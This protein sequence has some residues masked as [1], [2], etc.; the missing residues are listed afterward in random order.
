M[1]RSI[2]TLAL[3]FI[4]AAALLKTGRAKAQE[5]E[6]Q[7]LLLDIE[8]LTQMKSILSDMKTGYQ[9]Y[10]QGY[11]TISALSKGNFDLHNLYLSGL[12][13]VSPAV[14]NYGR[15]TEILLMQSRLVS[16]Y[17]EK[18]GLFRKSGSFSISELNYMGTVYA[19]LVSE[20]LN[21]LEELT[22][23]VTAGKLRMSDAERIR[24]I[25]RIYSAS[26]DKLGF[27]RSFNEQGII[28]S[29]QRTKEAGDTRSLKQL[30]GLNN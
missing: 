29:L 14:R 19:R 10:Q 1:N 20:T 4:L 23:I 11:G 17:K 12:L 7:Q 26:S 5:Q 3:A 15:V 21:D 28:L 9:I 6:M 24:G 2:K 8:K 16:E 27:L 18:S 30:Y 13:A 25:D 22:N